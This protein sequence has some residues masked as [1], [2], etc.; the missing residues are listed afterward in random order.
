MSARLAIMQAVAQ[1]AEEAGVYLDV[2]S[3]DIINIVGAVTLGATVNCEAFAQ[4]HS[5]E[6]HYDRSS[7][8]GMVRDSGPMHR[9]GGGR[10]E[11]G[12]ALRPTILHHPPPPCP[13]V[14]DRRGVRAEFLYVQKFTAPGES[15][16][17]VARRIEIFWSGSRSW[18]PS[19]YDLAVAP[20]CMVGARRLIM[21]LMRLMRSMTATSALRDTATLRWM[22]PEDRFLSTAN[23]FGMA[24]ASSN[25]K[26]ANRRR[27]YR[28]YMK[29][30]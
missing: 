29:P 8:V 17:L 13:F 7:F 18:P 27:V 15:T 3:F 23:T 6:V 28:A 14:L 24:G 5:S 10:R 4:A 25:V 21:R 16:Y 1:L 20:R 9:V 19:C 12:G 22:A 11:A 30:R 26:A 2:K